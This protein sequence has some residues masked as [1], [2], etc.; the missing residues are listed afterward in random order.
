[1]FFVNENEDEMKKAH[2]DS[3]RMIFNWRNMQAR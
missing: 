3:N 1:M 2:H